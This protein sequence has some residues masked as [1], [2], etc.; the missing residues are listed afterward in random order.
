[1][2]TNVE[3]AVDVNEKAR[4]V[5]ELFKKCGKD[6]PMWTGVFFGMAVEAHFKP[7]L[8]NASEWNSET[9]EF[10]RY[11]SNEDL[12]T[13]LSHFTNGIVHIM[14]L[15]ESVN[16]Q[17]NAWLDENFFYFML[18]VTGILSVLADLQS[19]IASTCSKELCKAL[20]AQE[21]GGAQ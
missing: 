16:P 2:K 3:Q 13:G 19:E 1:M 9:A 7:L 17:T 8:E 4:E 5:Q 11:L 12:S 14:G 20:E 18:E 21:K 6:Y 10:F 15:L